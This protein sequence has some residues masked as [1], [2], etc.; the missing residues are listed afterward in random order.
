M[1]VILAA[2]I[3]LLTFRFRKRMSLE[4]EVIAL[5]HQLSVLKRKRKLSPLIV[6]ADR[7]ILIWLYSTYPKA[8]NGC[9]L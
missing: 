2:L 3:S 9:G 7:F 4:L 8:I 1:R 5:R 6:P